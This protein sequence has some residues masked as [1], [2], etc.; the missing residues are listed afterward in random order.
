VVIQVSEIPPVTR[1]TLQFTTRLLDI[2]FH[3]D[4]PNKTRS[5][6]VA[7]K[8]KIGWFFNYNHTNVMEHLQYKNELKIKK[9]LTCINM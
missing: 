2:L 5:T 4:L 6:T 7:E 3:H 8:E 1:A 9:H